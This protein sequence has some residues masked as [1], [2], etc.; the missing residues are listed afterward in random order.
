MVIRNTS[1]YLDARIVSSRLMLTSA[2][3]SGQ[4]Q[5]LFGDMDDW[6]VKG[7]ERG[8]ELYFNGHLI[9]NEDQL[10]IAQLV[11]QR[12]ASLEGFLVVSMETAI[13]K[14]MAHTG[15]KISPRIV[16]CR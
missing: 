4:Q 10:R 3:F 13:G 11:V 6:R 12:K 7:F 15:F 1:P 2:D 8:A 9:L 5:G 14:I 16:A